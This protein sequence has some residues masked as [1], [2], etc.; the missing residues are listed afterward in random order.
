VKTQ[1]DIFRDQTDSSDVRNGVR[2][3][4]CL[5]IFLPNVGSMITGVI[6]PVT[7]RLT[8]GPVLRHRVRPISTNPA[9][10]HTHA[11]RS[12]RYRLFS[13]P[14]VPEER[15]GLVPLYAREIADRLPNYL[16]RTS[17]FIFIYFLPQEEIALRT[18]KTD[19]PNSVRR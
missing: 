8:T 11:S 9:P 2:K 18:G 7:R 6:Y 12:V 10:P 15:D 16:G 5:K 17:V 1:H 19:S 4:L 13:V 3:I 14:P